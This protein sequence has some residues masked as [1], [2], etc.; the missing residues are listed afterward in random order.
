MQFWVRITSKYNTMSEIVNNLN[1]GEQED[2]FVKYVERSLDS[3]KSRWTQKI[4]P[5]INKFQGIC[6]T[7]P[8]TS[9][10]LKDDAKNARHI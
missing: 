6:K 3:L 1:K 4:L 8:P 2:G 5:A 10:V 7:N 9:G